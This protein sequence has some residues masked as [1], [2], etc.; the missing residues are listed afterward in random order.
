MIFTVLAASYD[1]IA[2]DGFLD[3]WAIWRNT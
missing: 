3:V 2:A 1:I